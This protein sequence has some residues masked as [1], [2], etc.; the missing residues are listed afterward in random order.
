MLDEETLDE[1]ASAAILEHLQRYEEELMDSLSQFMYD[2]DIPEGDEAENI[3]EVDAR[4]ITKLDE[5][6][7]VL[8]GTDG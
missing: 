8:G 2:R 7:E 4:V 6:K 5:I 3:V 1:I